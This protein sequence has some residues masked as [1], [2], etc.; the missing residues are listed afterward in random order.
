MRRT[1]IITGPL[2]AALASPARTNAGGITVGL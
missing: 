1:A 2:A